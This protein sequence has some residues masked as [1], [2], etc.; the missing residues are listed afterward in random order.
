MPVLEV[1]TT[2]GDGH[3][4]AENPDYNVAHAAAVGTPQDALNNLVIGQR[5]V[6]PGPPDAYRIW[7]AVLMFNA[8][9]V[10]PVGAVISA[11]TISIYGFIDSSEQ[12]F[13]IYVVDGSDAHQPLVAADYGD[14][15]DATTYLSS[16]L[17]TLGFSIL[18]YSVLTLTQAGINL[19]STVAPTLFALRSDRE[20]DQTVPTELEW[21]SIKD[22]NTGL[23]AILTITY[24]TAP[25]AVTNPALNITQA[26]ASLAGELSDDGGEACDCG[27][28]WG[29]TEGYGITTLTDSKVTGETFAQPITGL[30]PGRAY[31]FR[32]FATNSAGTSYGADRSFTTPILVVTT[33]PAQNV[34]RYSATLNGILVNDGGTVCSVGFEW[35]T[36]PSNLDSSLIVSRGLS[37]LS[38]SATICSFLPKTTY[39]FRAFATN[40][41]G[42]SYGAILSF[43][44]GG[45][46]PPISG[47]PGIPGVP[48]VPG[49]P[50]PPSPPGG[51]FPP[52]PSPPFI[53]VPIPPIKTTLRFINIGLVAGGSAGIA[54]ILMGV[55]RKKRKILDNWTGRIYESREA[56]VKDII[57]VEKLNK[58]RPTYYQLTQK[59]PGRFTELKETVALKKR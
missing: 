9:T 57:E 53:P 7:R 34:L 59:Y 42:T 11:A 51:P 38:F 15:R 8:H 2:S 3:I 26:S 6:L 27:F 23:G 43:T 17:T 45:V 20:I 49:T 37:P 48:G 22:K 32:A 1:T 31:H 33:S 47:I 50:S 41:V 24:T 35:G 18:S 10:L 40:V 44:T 39:Y 16:P 5:W 36:D 52:D 29:E 21:V 55:G 4:F 54:M 12:D 56:C 28:E 25:T 13:L 19:I 58:V 30:G 14:L 46:L